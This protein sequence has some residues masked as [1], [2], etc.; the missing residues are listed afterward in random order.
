MYFPASAQSVLITFDE[1]PQAVD[2]SPVGARYTDKGIIFPD[3]S[4]II[5]LPSQYNSSRTSSGNQALVAR[6]LWKETDPGPLKISFTSEVQK[7]S[8]RTGSLQETDGNTMGIALT[9]RNKDG[10]V[11]DRA[12][13]HVSG[14]TDVNSYLEVSAPAE[15]GIWSVELQFGPYGN[16]F[17]VL[18]D[19]I[20][21][22]RQNTSASITHKP[23]VIIDKP[24][25]GITSVKSINLT[26]IIEGW[27]CF[28]DYPTQI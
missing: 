10:T 8:L 4:R 24:N 17:E 14:Q 22:F 16:R 25:S 27:D 18:D 28:Q 13:T 20:V 21:T 26:G 7:V 15:P 11:I 1:V 9:A 6:E 5:R 23:N 2:Y 12:V 19:L 3:S